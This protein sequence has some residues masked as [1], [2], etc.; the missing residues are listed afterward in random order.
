MKQRQIHLFSSSFL[1][2]QLA[3]SWIPISV[4]LIDL[5]SYWT[6][7]RLLIFLTQKVILEL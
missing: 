4:T 2:S 5:R 7:G 6:F 3:Y 1:D